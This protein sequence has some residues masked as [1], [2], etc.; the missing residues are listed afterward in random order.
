[1]RLQDHM[2]VELKLSVVGDDPDAVLDQIARLDRIGDAPL[3]PPIVHRLQDIYWDFADFAMRTQ[4][5]SIRLRS[6]DDQPFFTAKGGTSSS[7]GL[8][9][10]YELEVPATLENWHQIRAALMEEGAQFR[11]GSDEGGPADWLAAAG[12]VVTQHRETHRTVRDVFP[13]DRRNGSGRTAE[14]ALDRTTFR[15]DSIAVRYWEIEIEQVEPGRSPL[16]LGLPLMKLFP[17][18]LELST[19]GKYSRGLMI[20]RQLREAGRL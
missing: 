8:F 18:C 20:E 13:Y 6:I 7:G 10:R 5:L 1:M 16:D 19:M 17:G 2:E 12:L 11:T 14:L 3:G 15:F 4:R 9:E